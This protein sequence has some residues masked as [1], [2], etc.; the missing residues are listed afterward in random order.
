MHQIHITLTENAF[1]WILSVYELLVWNTFE[2]NLL[3]IVNNRKLLF[4]IHC[5]II[6]DWLWNS[7]SGIFCLKI[8][9]SKIFV[10]YIFSRKWSKQKKNEQKSV[11]MIINENERTIKIDRGNEEAGWEKNNTR[12]MK[13]MKQKKKYSLSRKFMNRIIFFF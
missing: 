4:S 6:I 2:W 10:I 11:L 5:S 3:C 7:S 12:Q 8:F 9:S 1:S 13:E